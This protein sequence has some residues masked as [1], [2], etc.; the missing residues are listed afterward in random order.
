MVGSMNEVKRQEVNVK[1]QEYVISITS[2]AL[3]ILILASCLLT[4]FP[5]SSTP[6]SATMIGSILSA[7]LADTCSLYLEKDPNAAR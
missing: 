1:R 3:L 6:R 4:Y 5:G 7:S 2:Y